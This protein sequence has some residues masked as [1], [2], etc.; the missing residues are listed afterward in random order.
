VRKSPLNANQIAVQFVGDLNV[1]ANFCGAHEGADVK[2]G[3]LDNA[4][5]FKGL[6]QAP[7]SDPLMSRLEIE[8]AIE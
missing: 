2:I 8:P 6:G 4:Q 1:L 7:Q 3:K 5:T